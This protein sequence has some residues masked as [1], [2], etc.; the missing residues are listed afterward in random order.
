MDWERGGVGR[1]GEV[2]DQIYV[3]MVGLEWKCEL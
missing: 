2:E 3:K 1:G